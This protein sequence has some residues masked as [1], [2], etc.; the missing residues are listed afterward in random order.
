V[1]YLVQMAEL[2]VGLVQLT[3]MSLNFRDGLK[4][5]GRLRRAQS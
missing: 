1:F 2:A 5:A 3:L 4:L